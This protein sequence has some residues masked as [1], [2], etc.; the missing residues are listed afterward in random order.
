MRNCG[1]AGGC[2]RVGQWIG[3]SGTLYSFVDLP[4]P[5]LHSKAAIAPTVVAATQAIPVVASRGHGSLRRCFHGLCFSLRGN[6][7]GAILAGVIS[8]WLKQPARWFRSRRLQRAF[9]HPPL[10]LQGLWGGSEHCAIPHVPGKPWTY[11]ASPLS[12]QCWQR[13]RQWQPRITGPTEEDQLRRQ[14]EKEKNSTHWSF[15]LL[16][17][18]DKKYGS[19]VL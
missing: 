1:G 7:V 16:C 6:G 5:P 15:L 14:R 10:K 8:S 18:G 11:L 3:S 2:L 4:R 13:G 17:D 12:R 19:V 9:R